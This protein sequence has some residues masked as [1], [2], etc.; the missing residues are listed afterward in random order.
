MLISPEFLQLQ[1][2]LHTTNVDYGTSGRLYV[3]IVQ[4]LITQL[5]TTSV[6]DYGCGK[7]TLGKHL[8]IPIKAYDPAIPGKEQTPAPADLVVCTDVL[9]HI[10]PEC[11]DAV[12]SDLARCTLRYGYFTIN[13]QPALKVY[14][15]GR[16]TH[17]I[18]E[19]QEWWITKLSP[20]FTIMKV[21]DRPPELQVFCQRKLNAKK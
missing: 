15:D 17:L 5:K 11:L 7:G 10:E 2:E 8:A 16:N 3:A 20:F 4:H 21:V 18:Q 14:A 12:L 13:T 1:R 19:G 9:E 6:L